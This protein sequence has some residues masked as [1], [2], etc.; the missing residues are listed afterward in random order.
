MKTIHFAVPALALTLA[1]AAFAQSQPKVTDPTL[2]GPAVKSGGVPGE[3]RQF[4]DGKVKG[5]ERMGTEIPHRL[6]MKAL[7]SLRGDTADASVRLSSEQDAKINK[8]N[9][10]FTAA[11]S[12]YRQAHEG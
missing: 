5:K 11:V 3:N 2:Q 4:G 9:D 12:S 10:A 7:D 8:I 6:F 1:T